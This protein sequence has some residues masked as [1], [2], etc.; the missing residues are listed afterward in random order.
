[1]G[2]AFPLIEFISD[3]LLAGEPVERW[4]V[5]DWQWVVFLGATLL[6]GLVLQL[7][8]KLRWLSVSGR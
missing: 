5:T 4:V 8:K 7:L 3:T 6:V 2:N 1:M